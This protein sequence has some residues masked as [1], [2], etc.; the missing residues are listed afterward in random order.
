MYRTD[1]GESAPLYS[2]TRI[3]LQETIQ[4]AQNLVN[5]ESTT[6]TDPYKYRA[7]NGVPLFYFYTTRP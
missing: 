3:N 4:E 7:D 1:L 5:Q 6:Q 2:L